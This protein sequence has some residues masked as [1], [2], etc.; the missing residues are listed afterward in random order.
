[1]NSKYEAYTV[2]AAGRELE[3]EEFSSRYTL[4]PFFTDITTL[5]T[6]N[7]FYRTIDTVDDGALEYDIDVVTVDNVVRSTQSLQEYKSDFILKVTW[8]NVAHFLG[9]A[10]EVRPIK[11]CVFMVTL[12][13]LIFPTKSSYLFSMF[14][15][16]K[17]IRFLTAVV[18]ASLWPQTGNAKF[19]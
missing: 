4:L 3:D 15:L 9:S 5:N 7:V 16:K 6:G 2:P 14:S 19:C 17:S 1:M 18:R 13:Y 11:I 12:P 8:E 10:A